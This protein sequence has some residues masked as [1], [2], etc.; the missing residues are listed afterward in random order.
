[1]PVITCGGMRFQHSW[2][3]GDEV[4]EESQKIVEACMYKALD[5]GINHFETARAYGTSEGQMGKVLV[6][7]PRSEIL[8]Q[9]K[10]GPMDDLDKFEATFEKTMGLLQQDYLDIFSFH[11]VNNDQ[12]LEYTLQCMEKVEVWKKEGRIR[13]VGFSTHA[14]TDVI[15][16]AIKTGAF[17]SVSLHY[18]YIYQDNRPALEEAKRQDMGVLI[19]SPNEK[20]GLLFNPSEKLEELTAPLHPMVFNGLFCLCSPEVKTLSCG[21]RKP[22]DFDAHLDTAEKVDDAEQL[23]SPIVERL[24]AE[25][26]KVLGEKWAKTWDVGLPAWHDVPGEVNIEWILRLR[27]LALAFD[28]VEYGKSRYNLLG[29]GQS[30]FPGVK[31]ESLEEFDFSEC[32]KDSPNADSILEALAEAHELLLDKPRKRLIVEDN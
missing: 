7:M 14:T 8:V 32:L 23:V 5:N 10:I 19:L 27:N 17:D 28:M 3:S 15:V 22:E 31:A 29:S 16:K 25:M 26:V 9:S 20:A 11:G 2:R 1:M 21:V 12:S 4:P 30:W 6:K 24:E 13:A 18:F